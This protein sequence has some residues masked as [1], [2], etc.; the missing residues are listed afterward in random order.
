MADLPK[1]AAALVAAQ[2][3][4]TNPKLDKTNPHYHSKYASLAGIID[5]IRPALLKHGLAIVQPIDS[6]EPGFV[7]VA[8]I[9]VHTSGETM[10]SAQ[11]AA[12]PSDPQKMGSLITY[13]RR[14]GIAAMLSVAGDEDDDANVAAALAQKTQQTLERHAEASAALAGVE[15]AISGATVPR[16]SKAPARASAAKGIRIDATVSKIEE[17]TSAA[18]KEYAWVH[19]EDA[20][21]F[22][23]FDNIDGMSIGAR[24]SFLLRNDR[25]GKP[26]II[27]DFSACVSDEEIPF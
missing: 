1:L 22:T 20:G 10:H 27:D 9:L 5:T 2:K 17:R 23:S 24:Y 18:G 7:S 26:T 16:A 19:T 12:A 8:T 25:D 21:R 11:R 3:D 15:R 14:Y 6:A 4:L 13:L